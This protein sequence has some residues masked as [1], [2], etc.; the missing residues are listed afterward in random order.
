MEQ[1]NSGTGGAG[2]T[3]KKISINLTDENIQKLDMI[4]KDSTMSQTD[5]INQAIANVPIIMLGNRRSIAE[6]FFDLRLM[7]QNDDYGAFRKEVDEVCQSL[8]LVMEKIAEL[9]H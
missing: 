3:A 7:M 1:R 4:K 6:C 9:K 2:M 5:I 8:N